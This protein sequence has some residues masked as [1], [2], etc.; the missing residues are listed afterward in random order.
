MSAAQGCE[1]FDFKQG[2]SRE[3]RMVNLIQTVVYR[4]GC[5]LGKLDRRFYS[6]S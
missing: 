6:D 2:G 4:G 3:G 1:L 5:L